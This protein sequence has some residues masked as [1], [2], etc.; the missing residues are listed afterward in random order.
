MQS[1]RVHVREASVAN[2]FSP[3]PRPAFGGNSWTTL[4]W[5]PP[6]DLMGR[7]PDHAT[8]RIRAAI[9]GAEEALH[10]GRPADALA[11]L[12]PL[13]SDLPDFGRRLLVEAARAGGDRPLLI[14]LLTPPRTIAELVDLSEA[15]IASRQFERA[16]SALSEYAALLSLPEPNMREL[17]ARITAGETIAR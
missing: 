8:A 17:Q 12:R 2:L 3:S 11:L 7:A 10:L 5:E 15:C 13:A 9:E 14:D 1:A 6:A 16:R 4:D